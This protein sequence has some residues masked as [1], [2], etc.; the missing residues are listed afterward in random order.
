MGLQEDDET[1]EGL[2]LILIISGA[3]PSFYMFVVV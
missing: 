3:G 2:V 1:E